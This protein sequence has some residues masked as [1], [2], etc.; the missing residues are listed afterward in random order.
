MARLRAGHGRGDDCARLAASA[1]PGGVGAAWLRD[2]RAGS[3]VAL[4]KSH[5]AHGSG[6]GGTV[7]N[8]EIED[9]DEDPYQR[10]GDSELHLGKIDGRLFVIT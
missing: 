8:R 1:A 5:I 2:S 3:N 9:A 4:K 7:N 10:D 6:H